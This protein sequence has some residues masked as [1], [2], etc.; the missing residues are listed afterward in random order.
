MELYLRWLEQHETGPGEESPLGLILCADKSEEHVELLQLDRSGIRVAEYLT[1]LP[2]REV[3][4]QKLHESIRRARERLALAKQDAR[5]RS[6]RRLRRRENRGRCRKDHEMTPVEVRRG[7]VD[8]LSS[9]WSAR[10]T[11]RTWR[12]K[13]SPRLPPAGI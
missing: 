13:S 7:L 1:E 11:D 2:P 6:P 9:I 8:A 5:S 12:R 3:L 4:E 10:R